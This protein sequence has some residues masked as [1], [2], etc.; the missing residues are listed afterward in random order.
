MTVVQRCIAIVLIVAGSAT[1]EAQVD[2]VL[3]NN[4]EEN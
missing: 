4:T 2:L 1:A 3:A